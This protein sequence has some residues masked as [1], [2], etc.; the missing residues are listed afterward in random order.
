M[1]SVKIPRVPWPLPSPAM[2]SE[3]GEGGYKAP[4]FPFISSGPTWTGKGRC[5]GH[6][7]TLLGRLGKFHMHKL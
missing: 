5:L 3:S 1:T 4:N 2:A 7:G 6:T